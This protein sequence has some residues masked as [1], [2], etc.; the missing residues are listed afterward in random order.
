MTIKFQYDI[1]AASLEEQ[2]NNQG[3]TLGDYSETAEEIIDAL[4]MLRMRALITNR[5]YEKITARLYKK[6][7]KHLTKMEEN[8]K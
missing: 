1:F 2:A 7:L 8:K 3:Y 4:I 5:E 6:L